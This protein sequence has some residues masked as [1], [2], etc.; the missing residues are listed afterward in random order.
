MDPVRQIQQ[1]GWEWRPDGLGQGLG[2]GV[3]FSVVVSGRRVKT[4]VPLARVWVTFDQEL[5][6]VG[7]PSSN[8]VGAPFSIGGLFGF[9]KKAAKS[10]GSVAKKVVPKAVQKAAAKIVSVAKKAA[11]AT[12]NVAAKPAEL[13]ARAV[14]K[15]PVLGSIVGAAGT[16]ANLPTHAAAQLV[17]GRRL[18]HIAVDQFK[19]ALGATKTLAPYVQT[20]VSVV[21]GLGTGISAGLGG[22]LALASGKPIDQALVDAAAGALPGGPAA[23]AAFTVAHDVMAGKPVD[24]IAINAL[25]IAPAAKQAL[26]AGV[27]AARDLAHGKNV[28]QALIDRGTEALPPQLRQAV[29]VGTAIA[30]ARSLQ[31][32]AAAAVQGAVAL[33]NVHGAAVAAAKQFAAGVRSPAV[34]TALRKGQAAQAALTS[35]VKQAQAGHPQ[36]KNVVRALA[37]VRIAQSR[38]PVRSPLQRAFG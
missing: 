31:Q 25:P 23:R 12:L 19:Q 10:I 11:V 2:P 6:K 34:I 13:A 30:H 1:L 16:L 29:Q 35:V 8:S 24:Q 4:F 22:A 26:V 38:L 27:K 36:A 7:C 20:I 37:A 21:P 32:G 3:L 15:V 17:S 5:Q 14:S 28:A 9:V 33:T 18:D